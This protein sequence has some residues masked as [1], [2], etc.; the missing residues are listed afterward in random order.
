MVGALRLFGGSSNPGLVKRIA[1]HLNVPLGHTELIRFADTEVCYQILENIRGADVFVV[2]PTAPPVNESIM[3]LLIMIDAFKRSSA[4]RITAV[5]PY[6]GYGRQ[7]R[8]D[9]P[10]VPISAKLVADLL[11]KAGTSRVI[12]MDLHA[13]QIQGFFDIPVDHLYAAPVML[14]YLDSMSVSNLVIVSPDAGGVE[15]ARA[16][17]KRLDV[18]LA[19]MDK[20]RGDHNQIETI[21]VIGDVE[22]KTALIVDDIVDSA[23]TLI[24]AAEALLEAKAERVLACCTHAVLSGRAVERVADSEIDQLIVSDTIPLSAEKAACPK[25]KVLS[26]AVLL[27]KAIQSV[28]DETS[29]SSLFV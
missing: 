9:K 3:E 1:D 5:L 4:N 26:V 11:S 6:Y 16:Y 22:G 15:R 12:T 21:R 18:A 20:R 13:G 27:G 23:G 17:A 28:H 24:R 19:V 7:D 29:V 14:E 2:Q 8:K 10:R 25:I